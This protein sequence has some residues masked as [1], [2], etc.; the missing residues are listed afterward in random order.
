MAWLANAPSAPQLFPPAGVTGIPICHQVSGLGL[1]YTSDSAGICD[2]S[3]SRR[4]ASNKVR[5]SVALSG[6][7]ASAT[8][9]TATYLLGG[10]YSLNYSVACGGNVTTVSF[11]VSGP[12]NYSNS[13]NTCLG[14]PV[15]VTVAGLNISA[16]DSVKFVPGSASCFDASPP[17]AWGTGEKVGGLTRH[18]SSKVS[19]LMSFGLG[20]QFRFCYKVCASGFI[21]GWAKRERRAGFLPLSHIASFCA[22]LPSFFLNCSLGDRRRL[23]GA[24]PAAEHQ[25]PY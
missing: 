24:V 8:N 13:S 1:D 3:D 12:S 22:P 5:G 7:T 16:T 25:G 11:N 21:R 4:D 10:T 23:R 17:L 19:A 15:N 14:S 2:G 6:G 9:V 18:S 20:G